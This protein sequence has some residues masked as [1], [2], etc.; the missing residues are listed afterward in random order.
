MHQLVTTEYPALKSRSR[1]YFVQIGP[2]D[3][4][5]EKTDSNG[6]AKLMK[7]RIRKHVG[8]R[9]IVEA[10][11]GGDLTDIG[12]QIFKPLMGFPEDI[13]FTL[14]DLADR[15]RCRLKESRP[16]L[17]GHNCF[18]DLIFFYQGFIGPLPDTVEAFQTVIHGLFPIVVDTKYLATYDAGSI[19]PLSSLEETNR[20]LANISMPTI[21]MYFDCS[22]E[23]GSEQ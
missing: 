17:V 12:D 22:D 15:V 19:N 11:V 23:A 21:S 10:L 7:E 13:S 9:W 8:C 20:K 4:E 14:A 5:R 6:K 3:P 16:I 1:S 18:M 2:A